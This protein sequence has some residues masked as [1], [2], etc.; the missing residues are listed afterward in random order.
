MGRKRVD[1]GTLEMFSEGLAERERVSGLI[2]A[3]LS[4]EGQAFWRTMGKEWRGRRVSQIVDAGHCVGEV[5]AGIEW[6][7]GSAE[8]FFGPTTEEPCEAKGNHKGGRK[9]KV[10]R[11]T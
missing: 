6:E 1:K 8:R 11:A 2:V 9:K 10:C 3:S 5:V 4:E 7:R